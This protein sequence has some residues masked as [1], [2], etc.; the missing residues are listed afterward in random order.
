MVVVLYEFYLTEN[1]VAMFDDWVALAASAMEHTHG[2]VSVERLQRV[3]S[4]D[5]CN[6]LLRFNEQEDAWRWAMSPEH[7]RVLE[8][9]DGQ[10]TQPWRTETFHIRSVTSS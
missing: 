10:H 4:S 1:G 5:S 7:I 3:E 6:M 8:R 2:L 9:L